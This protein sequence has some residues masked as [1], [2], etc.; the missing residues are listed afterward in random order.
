MADPHLGGGRDF[1]NGQEVAMVH[2]SYQ[3][4]SP[5]GSNEGRRRYMGGGDERE[6]YRGGAIICSEWWSKKLLI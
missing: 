6:E 4:R 1:S 2:S 5:E 3:R